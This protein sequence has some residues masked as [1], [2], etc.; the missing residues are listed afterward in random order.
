MESFRFVHA[1][2]LH[3]GSPFKGLMAVEPEIGQ[4]VD[5]R[6]LFS[7]LGRNHDLAAFLAD[8][9]QDCVLAFMDHGGHIGLL[10]IGPAARQDQIVNRLQCNSCFRHIGLAA[11]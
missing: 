2:D 11:W 4:F 3:I 5:R 9:L 6:A 10:R 7:V 8:F 1:A